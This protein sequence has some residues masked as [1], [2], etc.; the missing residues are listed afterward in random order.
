LQLY[1]EFKL[2]RLLPDYFD[3][4]PLLFTNVHFP[5]LPYRLVVASTG[6]VTTS[7]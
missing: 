7:W 5:F 4:L 1:G 2:V 6:R 3:E